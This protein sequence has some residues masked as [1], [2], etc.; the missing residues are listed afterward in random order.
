VEAQHEGA[1]ADVEAALADLLTLLERYAGGHV[2][3]AVVDMQHP[4]LSDE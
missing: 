3:S 2:I 4:E 1:R